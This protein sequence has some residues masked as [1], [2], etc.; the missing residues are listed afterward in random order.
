MR[1]T[2]A[3]LAIL[4]SVALV[5]SA[6]A[7]DTNSWATGQ[8]VGPAVGSPASTYT[9][10]WTIVPTLDWQS[11]FLLVGMGFQP[12][13]TPSSFSS[14][15]APS[16]WTFANPSDGWLQWFGNG[17]GSLGNYDTTNGLTSAQAAST[18]WSAQITTIHPINAYNY[19]LDFVSTTG[20]DR[21]R[22]SLQTDPVPEP[23]SLALLGTG[24]IGLTTIIRRR[25]AK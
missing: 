19:H 2:I 5:Q 15:M 9:F 3:I 24:L 25:R 1:R 16:G 22:S 11:D 14:L 23:A 7:V 12:D 8:V 17:D 13:G 20:Q 10:T 21:G 18:T 6:G 4:L